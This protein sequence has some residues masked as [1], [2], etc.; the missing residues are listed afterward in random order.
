MDG[1][2]V[3]TCVLNLL[4][5]LLRRFPVLHGAIG[6]LLL[7]LLPLNTRRLLL[8]ARLLNVPDGRGRLL[9]R[10]LRLLRRPGWLL[11]RAECM[12][13]G[14]GDGRALCRRIRLRWWRRARVP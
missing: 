1:R 9:L 7:V 11:I 6:C 3:L 14:S 4:L 2:T 12:R 13:L 10:L 5:L 8:I